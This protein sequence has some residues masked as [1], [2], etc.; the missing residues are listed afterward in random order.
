D[1]Y[2]SVELAFCWSLRTRVFGFL[3][4]KLSP[5]NQ[6][7]SVLPLSLSPSDLEHKRTPKPGTLT[8]WISL[9]SS[10]ELTSLPRA[11]KKQ[12][13]NLLIILTITPVDDQLTSS[14]SFAG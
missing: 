13:D 6:P 1:T 4:W 5:G 9:A 8:S 7:S 3:S 14:Y 10:S 11:C 2:W 12:R